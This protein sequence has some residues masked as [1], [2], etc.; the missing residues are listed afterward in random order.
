MKKIFF[1]FL[2]F[3]STSNLIAEDG[4]NCWLRY[5]QVENKN[6][7]LSYQQAI[8]ELQVNGNSATIL[9]AK[10]ELLNGLKGLLGK[11]LSAVS[12]IQKDG[13]I[14]IGNAAALKY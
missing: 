5:N 9:A 12:T 7:L 2:L 6:L 14:I 13:T 11:N 1:L 10:T 3:V 4:Y 8:A